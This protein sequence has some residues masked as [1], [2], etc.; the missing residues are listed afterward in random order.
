MGLWICISVVLFLFCAALAWYLLILKRELRTIRRELSLAREHS[1]NRQLTVSL[2]DRDLTELG[3]ELNKNLDYQKQLKHEARQSELKL[4]QSVSDIAHD[5][6]TPLTVIKGN[7]QMLAQDGSISSQA[8]RYVKICQSK[9]EILKD[10]VNDFFELSVLESDSTRVE[11]SELDITKLLMQFVI[12]HETVIREHHLLPDL[13]LPERSIMVLAD[14]QMLLRMLGNLLGNVLK[15]AR[16]TFWI[17]VETAGGGF[18]IDADTNLCCDS[19]AAARC[20]ITFANRIEADVCPD[21]GHLFERAYRGNETGTGAGLGLYIVRLLA[22]K[23]GARVYATKEE[24]CLALHM[25]F[26]MKEEG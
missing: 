14:R 26:R 1:Y 13:R 3:T 25:V 21:A 23:Q 16:E 18:D 2:F 20:R 10:M 4:K 17:S 6:R 11:L 24:G 5:L 15:Y 8:G 19:A 7:L 22:D 12:D 9:S